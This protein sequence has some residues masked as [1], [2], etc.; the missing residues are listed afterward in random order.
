[1]EAPAL[2]TYDL[3]NAASRPWRR[4]LA[5]AIR[6]PGELL[7]LLGLDPE[8]MGLGAEAQREFPLRVP[9][10]YAARMRPGD[11]RDPLLLQVLPL[12][13]ETDPAPGFSADPVGDLA[14]MAA[15]GLLHKYQGR[16]LLVITGACAV[17]CRY[18]FRRHFPY[19][20][21]NPAGEH[22]AESLAYIAA[23]PEIDEVILS[24]GDPLSLPD[25]RLASMAGDL[26]AIPHLKRLRIHTRLPVVLPARVDHGLVR[27][28]SRLARETALKPVVVIHANHPH[29]I[30]GAVAGAMK[31]LAGAGAVLLNQS[32]LLR[33]V[34]D[35]PETL[36]AL[37]EALF[38]AGVL[39]Y[40]L[41]RLDRV[42]GAAHF[43][44]PDAEAEGIMTALRARLPGYLVPA[45]VCEEPGAPYKRPL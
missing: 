41:H 39:P 36:A 4:E 14:A 31:R 2:E 24:G 6:D 40:Y 35:D 45:F 38:A 33:G 28:L 34:N 16:A 27:W 13:S 21:A 19:G 23:R 29:E 22:W 8:R 20:E 15:P 26:A 10:G 42:R 43:E 32:V 5:D 1:M 12:A 11:P 18:C 30:D 44:V 3:E 17:H 37:S 7:A 9:R 25:R